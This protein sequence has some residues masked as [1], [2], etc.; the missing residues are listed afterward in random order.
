MAL[1][2][3]F[4]KD[5]IFRKMYV[6]GRSELARNAKRAEHGWCAH[7]KDVM[8][9]MGWSDVWESESV[10]DLDKKMCEQLGWSEEKIKELSHAHG[11]TNVWKV[12]L[13]ECVRLL[14]ERTM[15][16]EMRGKSSLDLY[17][18]FKTTLCVEPY[19]LQGDAS[20]RRGRRF[21]TRLRLSTSPLMISVGRLERIADRKDRV[22]EFCK[23]EKGVGKKVVEDELHFLFYCPL[24]DEK[25]EWMWSEIK[26]T[27]GEGT[28]ELLKRV[29]KV[30]A[31]R[32]ALAGDEDKKTQNRVRIEEVQLMGLLLGGFGWPEEEDDPKKQARIENPTLTITKRFVQQSMDKRRKWAEA[33]ADRKLRA[34]KGRRKADRHAD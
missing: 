17:R 31:R 29:E 15:K 3:F 23:E 16:K 6:N 24:Y 8:A 28:R 7:T 10:D 34:K 32:K 14:E 20:D 27:N 4:R 1:H 26:K 12:M 30:T 5:S 18:V 2:A 21:M 19:L 22:C 25:R 33:E 9:E 11:P 13:N